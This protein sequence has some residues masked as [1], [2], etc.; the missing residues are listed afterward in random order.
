M[1]RKEWAEEQVEDAV[2]INGFDDAIVGATIDGR[3]VYDYNRMI[4]CLQ[5]EGM[6]EEK[7]LEWME[8]NTI[9]ATD[10]LEEP[11]ID[12]KQFENL[13]ALQCTKA[14]ICGWFDITDKTLERWCKRTYGV[15]FSEIFKQKRTAGTIA[16][17]RALYQAATNSKN[18]KAMIFWLKNHTEMN[19]QIVVEN[20]IQDETTAEMEAFFV[21]QRGNL[22][23]A[24]NRP[25]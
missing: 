14:E 5:K 16:V 7:A 21:K 18:I 12:Q 11:Q 3:V 6:T 1:D 13:C 19:D 9:R 22:R 4:E 23:T 15:G 20:H 25:D 10:Y 8:Y 2:F 24:G 17:R